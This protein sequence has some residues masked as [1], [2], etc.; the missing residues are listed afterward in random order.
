MKALKIVACVL[1]A[2]AGWAP[3][4]QQTI[5]Q[6][7]S[8]RQMVSKLN[9]NF[10]ENYSSISTTAGIVA[11][12]VEDVAA[13]VPYTGAAANVDLGV[14]SITAESIGTP[15]DPVGA[16]RVSATGRMYIGSKQVMEYGD[17][18]SVGTN[19]V[20]VHAPTV[21][22]VVYTN[23]IKPY[24]SSEYMGWT[25]TTPWSMGT[26]VIN[27]G[28]GP[29]T[30]GAVFTKSGDRFPAGDYRVAVSVW[31][32]NNMGGTLTVT[33]YWIDGITS[34]LISTS[35]GGD[36]TIQ[37]TFVS[38]AGWTGFAVKFA[39]YGGPGG[40]AWR[41]DHFIVSTAA[42]GAVVSRLG[43]EGVATPSVVVTN[44]GNADTI[45]VGTTNVTAGG[46]GVVHIGPRLHSA[47]DLAVDGVTEM[48]SRGT[49][50]V[51]WR[52]DGKSNTVEY[53]VGSA[54]TSNDL[55]VT[56]DG[57]AVLVLRSNKTVEVTGDTTV[58]GALKITG[59]VNA[60]TVT[61]LAVITDYPSIGRTLVLKGGDGA[62]GPPTPVGDVVLQGGTGGATPGSVKVASRLD[63]QNNMITN[64]GTIAATNGA[65]LVLTGRN[66]RVTAPLQP[67][68]GIDMQ[69][70]AI[71]NASTIAATNGG[72]LAL[73]GNTVR[74]DAPLVL[75]Q[76]TDAGGNN[77]TN[78]GRMGRWLGT[79]T[80]AWIDFTTPGTVEMQGDLY[81]D[82][83]GSEFKL[84]D[85]GD[86]NRALYLGY[87]LH[88]VPYDSAD[89][90]AGQNDI[91]AV[92]TLTFTNRTVISGDKT[93]TTLG[94]VSTN[95]V[96]LVGVD[97]DYDGRYE[98]VPAEGVYTF[99]G[100][101][102]DEIHLDVVED[103]DVWQLYYQ[104]MEPEPSGIWCPVEDFPAGPWWNSGAEEE[105]G[106]G[107]YGT[108][109]FTVADD[110]ANTRRLRLNTL[111]FTNAAVTDLQ[112]ELYDHRLRMYTGDLDLLFTVDTD[113]R[114]VQLGDVSET[115]AGGY[116]SI[117]NGIIA[118]YGDMD[119][120]DND[121]VNVGNIGTPGDP[122][123]EIYV[124]NGS[125]YMGN[126]KLAVSNGGISVTS[127]NDA[128]PTNGVTVGT[129]G[130][131]ATGTATWFEDLTLSAFE[132]IDPA[133]P[134]GVAK[135]QV[136]NFLYGAEFSPNEWGN[137]I[138]QLKHQYKAQSAVYPYIH[139]ASTNTARATTNTWFFGM[140][141]G[142]IGVEFTNH[143]SATVTVTN[144]PGVWHQMP[145]FPSWTTNMAESTV[146]GV[147]VSNMGPDTAI[148]V[149]TD[150]HI[151]GEK[152][153]TDELLPHN[154]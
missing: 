140:T 131:Y 52:T 87:G 45:T 69:L 34:N 18:V 50:L 106:S 2:M 148:L 152:L 95:T 36:R 105:V 28:F 38:P 42:V 94:V 12:L 114:T 13:L 58:N 5:R 150:I 98:Y 67:A 21:W 144:Q 90:D 14:Y 129:N 107:Y 39:G 56:V 51:M 154:P 59:A 134:G 83:A 130:I 125:I 37:S 93:S 9:S 81:V 57:T 91:T 100:G 116:M 32:A 110:A 49:N 29:A 135:V 23:G 120:N 20:V 86:G 8:V 133:G 78:I 54:A 104:D 74:V 115:G 4:A 41:M 35:S 128:S 6:T 22:T 70:S 79:T 126:A 73:T 122:V 65:D 96:Y 92:K 101:F 80:E 124:S 68:R 27:I 72:T 132:F 85:R 64:A 84:T 61:P 44:N 113:S 139:T 75:R 76:T 25:V 77:I 71:T 16:V 7:D 40:V 10:T 151:E 136:T 60:A 102:G 119:M 146:I 1:L 89:I 63:V 99:E 33:L 55:A 31:D 26:G 82:G 88:M 19:A 117:G 48:N 147:V 17:A 111:T 121:I 149:D 46:A 53:L 118:T 15:A 3:A 142:R 97:G 108:N 153:G 143:Y 103:N 138:L 127:T 62:F 123:N 66:V 43:P 24:P 141:S 47:G 30:G 112:M 11:G 145:Q 137:G 109:A